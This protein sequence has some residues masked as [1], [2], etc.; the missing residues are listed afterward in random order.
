MEGGDLLK[1]NK[2]GVLEQQSVALVLETLQTH[3]PETAK[4]V[5]EPKDFVV[6]FKPDR[7]TAHVTIT[8][9]GF[10]KGGLAEDSD[11]RMAIRRSYEMVREQELRA[12]RE[13]TKLEYLQKNGKVKES[14]YKEVK[15][16]LNELYGIKKQ[17][18][19]E[20]V[21]TIRGTKVVKEQEYVYNFGK[22][23]DNFV[24]NFYLDKFKDFERA[25]F[26]EF[27]SVN[28]SMQ[29]RVVQDALKKQDN[30]V[31]LILSNALAFKSASLD[32]FYKYGRLSNK[33]A[34]NLSKGKM[35]SGRKM[36]QYADALTAMGIIAF[37][38]GIAGHLYDVA[39]DSD[40]G[41]VVDV[42]DLVRKGAKD[43]ALFPT[44]VSP[45]LTLTLIYL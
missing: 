27:S 14:K 21:R 43:V 45:F 20:E 35:F 8:S 32:A 1:F 19:S 2:E 37:V 5:I 4:K 36:A 17:S 24:A 16:M 29:R 33:M 15:E 12:I 39:T 22:K 3:F 40:T 44:A 9:D 26:Y 34:D 31:G 13:N 11:I 10:L 28:P 6:R 41:D 25:I 38:N 42:K 30:R 23:N 7:H 18:T